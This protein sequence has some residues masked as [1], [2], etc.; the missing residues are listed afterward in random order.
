ML[1]IA[2]ISDLHFCEP[3]LAATLRVFGGGV[4]RELALLTQSDILDVAVGALDV[5]GNL[6]ETLMRLDPDVI[7]VS[8]DLT[9][10]GDDASFAQFAAWCEPLLT[11][12]GGHRNRKFLVVPGNHDAL[13]DHFTCLYRKIVPELPFT[14]RW[15]ARKYI[16]LLEPLTSHLGHHWKSGQHLANFETLLARNSWLTANTIVAEIP[17]CPHVRVRLIPFLTT[18]TDPL[19]MNLAETRAHEWARLQNEVRVP[20]MPGSDIKIVITH[21][22]PIAAP[23]GRDGRFAHAYN[24]MPEGTFFLAELQKAGVDLLMHGHQ[25]EYSLVK[26]DY[27]LGSAGHAFALGSDRSSCPDN[28]GFNFITVKDPNQVY[29]QRYRYSKPAGFR[30]DAATTFIPLERHRPND[31]ETLSARYELKQYLYPSGDE[32]D[33]NAFGPVQG[34]ARG[35][36]YISG[37]HF[38]S[39]RETRFAQVREVLNTDGGRVRLLLVDPSLVDRLI[40]AGDEIGANG[41]GDLWGRKEELARLKNEARSSLDALGVLYESLSR[42]QR[43]RLDVRKAHTLIPFGAYVRDPDK[44]WGKM[45][46]KILPVGAMGDLEA[47]ILRLNRRGDMALY[48]YYLKH[49]KYLFLRSTRVLGDWADDTDLRAD[50]AFDVLEGLTLQ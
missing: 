33:A 32:L 5:L 47:P 6:R 15:A 35:I 36:V 42:E 46:V 9:T 39:A 38:R 1:K 20:P 18:S 25:H 16:K 43:T 45:A 4:S 44:P 10:F 48:D 13:Q 29:L 11:R 30:P 31:A 34:G 41:P 2:H 21:H 14:L 37:R 7:V 22:N 8:G 24:G 23:S 49:L 26:F 3:E 19:W 50:M 40:A 28:G 27:D 17:D 12:Q